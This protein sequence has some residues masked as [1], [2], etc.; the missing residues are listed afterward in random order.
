MAAAAKSAAAAS[1]TIMAAKMAFS[2]KAE[3]AASAK[4]SYQ[5]AGG[6]GVSDDENKWRN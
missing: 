3:A 1:E 6:T 2:E 5:S 4:E